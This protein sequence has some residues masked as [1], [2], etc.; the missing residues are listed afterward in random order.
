MWQISPQAAASKAL[1]NSDGKTFPKWLP[2]FSFFFIIKEV[3]VRKKKKNRRWGGS[4][5]NEK[6]REED[7]LRQLCQNQYILLQIPPQD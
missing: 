7:H 3:V 6:V 2:L 1:K 5:E 4:R